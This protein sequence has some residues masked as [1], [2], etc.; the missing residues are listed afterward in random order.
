MYVYIIY[1]HRHVRDNCFHYP[2]ERNIT[3]KL[4]TKKLASK[5]T[6]DFPSQLTLHFVTID[7]SRFKHATVC[8][9]FGLFSRHFRGKENREHLDVTNYERALEMIAERSQDG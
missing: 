9:C 7:L 3:A 1:Y 6:A 2:H 5:L 8:V 4:T